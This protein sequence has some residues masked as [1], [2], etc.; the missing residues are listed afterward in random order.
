[1]FRTLA[2]L[3]IFIVSF[4]GCGEDSPTSSSSEEVRL[5]VKNELVTFTIRHVYISDTGKE[6]WGRDML[7]DRNITPGKS[8]NFT[9]KKGV[10][11]LKVVDHENDAY[12]KRNVNLNKNFTWEVTFLD[13]DIG[14]F[15]E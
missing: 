1:M 6:Q 8:I 2:V 11:D 14:S 10:Y 4:W 7:G 5:T 15:F 9:V 13:L 12:I 3:G